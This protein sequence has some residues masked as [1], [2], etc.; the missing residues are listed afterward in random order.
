MAICRIVQTGHPVLRRRA[1]AVDP[2]WIGSED[3]EVLIAD[4]IE[5]MREAPGVGLAAPQIGVDRQIF[6]VEDQISVEGADEIEHQKVPLQVFV[7]PQLTTIGDESDAVVFYEGCLSVSGFAA[8]VSRRRRVRIDALDERGRE[9]TVEWTGWPAR[10]LQHEYEHLEGRL[11]VD[12][13][14]SRT[15]SALDELSAAFES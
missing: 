8:M 4:M 2:G 9:F 7:N 12:R 13:M 6:V 5:T 15:F 11:Y 10:I 3:F 1:Q 14:D